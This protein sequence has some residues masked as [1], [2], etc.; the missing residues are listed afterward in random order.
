MQDAT[1][2][3]LATLQ[4]S[5]ATPQP[6]QLPRVLHS[7]LLAE[8]LPLTTV[9]HTIKPDYL[10]QAA[11]VL[12]IVKPV[13]L[14]ELADTLRTLQTSA[15]PVVYLTVYAPWIDDDNFMLGIKTKV[16]DWAARYA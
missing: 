14:A 15:A 16:M 9:L 10:Y 3:D 7:L 8:Q 1:Q 12:M 5:I 13:P 6:T 2:A 11:N 4:L